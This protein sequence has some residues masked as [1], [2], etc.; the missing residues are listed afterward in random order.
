MKQSEITLIEA[1]QALDSF[2]PVKI[3]FNNIVLYND[4][5]SEFEAEP[6]SGIYGEARVPLEVI[7]SRLWRI[8]DY[9]VTDIKISIVEHHHSIIELYGYYRVSE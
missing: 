7:P 3:L 5:D 4:Y 8:E 2:C 1:L 6:G 9:V